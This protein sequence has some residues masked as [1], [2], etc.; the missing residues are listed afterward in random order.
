MNAEHYT[1]DEHA[2]YLEAVA[3]AQT[4]AAHSYFDQHIIRMDDAQYWVADEGSYETL[5]QDLVDRI[6][7]TI[8]AGRVDEF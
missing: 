1:A 4:R 7:M 5:M 6:V 2:R 8:P 3:N